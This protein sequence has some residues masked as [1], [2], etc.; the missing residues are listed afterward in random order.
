M[1]VQYD[2]NLV[3]QK[4]FNVIS[5]YRPFDKKFAPPLSANTHVIPEYF[6]IQSNEHL[7]F[8]AVQDSS[9]L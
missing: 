2:E 6:H 3:A 8:L 5:H 4:W 1:V 9:I 7:T